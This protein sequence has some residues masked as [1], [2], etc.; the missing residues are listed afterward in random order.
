M[1][2]LRKRIRSWLDFHNQQLKPIEVKPPLVSGHDLMDHLHISPGPVV[3]K[4]LKTLTDLQ[5]EGL[6]NNR[7]EALQRAAQLLRKWK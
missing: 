6:I 4:L 3:G 7:D 2:L 5:W 1:E